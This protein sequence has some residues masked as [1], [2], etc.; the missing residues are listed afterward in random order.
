MS[1]NYTELQ[2]SEI[3]R[4]SNSV[5]NKLFE[6]K[7][8]MVL[9]ILA[10]LLLGTGSYLTMTLVENWGP[11]IFGCFVVIGY[12]TW[13]YY[14][15]GA[16]KKLLQEDNCDTHKFAAVFKKERADERK[17]CLDELN[18]KYYPQQT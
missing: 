16:W 18:K 13:G 9:S 6:Y 8:N 1:E 11:V 17:R 14:N 7:E 4:K 5:C 2:K 3:I 15:Y 12:C 10:S